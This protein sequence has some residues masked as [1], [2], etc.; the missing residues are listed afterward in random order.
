MWLVE[1]Q[2]VGTLSNED[3]NVNDN[4]SENHLCGLLFYT[5]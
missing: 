4:D 3:G 1:T 2:I 5:S